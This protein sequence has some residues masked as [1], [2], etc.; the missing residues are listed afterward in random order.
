MD[1]DIKQYQKPE[2]DYDL[3]T[4]QKEW[5]N[6]IKENFDACNSRSTSGLKV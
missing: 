3:S 4:S 2:L 1:N 5:N 6:V